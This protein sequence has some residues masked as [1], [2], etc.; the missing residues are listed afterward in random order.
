M[1]IKPGRSDDHHADLKI[2]KKIWEKR[3]LN[4]A[5]WRT[6]FSGESG[7]M[8]AYR[9]KNGWKD[10]DVTLTSTRAAADEVG[11]PGTYDRLMA[12]N[13]LNIE[14]SVGEMIEY[15]PELSSK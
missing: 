5:V 12:N 15:K 1:T 14:R 3:G 2:W 8:I 11:G 7:Y 13:K 10:L 4:V 9:L 6:F